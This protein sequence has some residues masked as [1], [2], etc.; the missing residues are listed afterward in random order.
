MV[1]KIYPLSTKLFGGNGVGDLPWKGINLENNF[2]GNLMNNWEVGAFGKGER[3]MK[4]DC[5][6]QLEKYEELLK[7][8]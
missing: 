2:L 7:P 6:S 8:K 4:L 3:A 1:L 5:G